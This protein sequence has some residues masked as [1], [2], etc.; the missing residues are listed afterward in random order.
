[1]LRFKVFLGSRSFCRNGIHIA[2]LQPLVQPQIISGLRHP[3]SFQTDC[4]GSSLT[5]LYT[6]PGSFNSNLLRI[7]VQNHGHC[8]YKVSTPGGIYRCIYRYQP[9]IIQFTKDEI[10]PRH[11]IFLPLALTLCNGIGY[12]CL[13]LIQCQFIIRTVTDHTVMQPEQ[14]SRSRPQ[15]SFHCNCIHSYQTVAWIG[16]IQHILAG[17][18]FMPA[19]LR[20]AQYILT[21][22]QDL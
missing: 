2:A 14:F 21:T 8:V 1:M 4:Q 3:D 22:H 13:S 19:N 17:F 12:A 10:F 7:K 11:T 6:L 15:S 16:C 18:N 20:P 5:V 9:G